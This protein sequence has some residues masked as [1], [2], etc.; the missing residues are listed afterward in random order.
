MTNSLKSGEITAESTQ[1][2]EAVLKD[3][4]D[5]PCDKVQIVDL[6]PAIVVSQHCGCVEQLPGQMEVWPT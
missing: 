4:R 1:P 2:L 5:Y 6:D 3:G